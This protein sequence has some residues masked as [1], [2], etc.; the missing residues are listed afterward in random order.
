[1][2]LLVSFR[3]N[4]LRITKFDYKYLVGDNNIKLIKKLNFKFLKRRFFW[5][6]S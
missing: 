4:I 3:L 2:F 1:M 5:D 6:Y